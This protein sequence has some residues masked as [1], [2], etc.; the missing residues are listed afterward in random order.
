VCHP[1]KVARIE[2][3]RRAWTRRQSDHAALFPPSKA[4]SLMRAVRLRVFGS[5]LLRFFE[6]YAP[7]RVSI[8][9]F[10]RLMVASP[11]LVVSHFAVVFESESAGF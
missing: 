11:R 10:C 3:H 6:R 2:L 4:I 7:D 8:V 9:T 1:P 5:A